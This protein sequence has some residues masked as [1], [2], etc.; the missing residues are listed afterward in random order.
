MPQLPL[1]IGATLVLYLEDHWIRKGR[2]GLDFHVDL[3][4]P[5][6]GTSQTSRPS[7]SLPILTPSPTAKRSVEVEKTNMN[8]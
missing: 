2:K 5:G 8:K 6:R 4:N 7:P 3:P 1:G